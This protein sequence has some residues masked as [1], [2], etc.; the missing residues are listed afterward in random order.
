MVLVRGWMQVRWLTR[1]EEELCLCF[2]SGT[3]NGSSDWT[4]A[5]KLG[6]RRGT[7]SYFHVGGATLGP[8]T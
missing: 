5:V 2:A 6:W 3:P 1:R 7:F 4:I 8:A